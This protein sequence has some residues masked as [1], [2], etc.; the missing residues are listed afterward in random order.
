MKNM[1]MFTSNEVNFLTKGAKQRST[2]VPTKGEGTHEDDE[3]KPVEVTEIVGSFNT[4]ALNLAVEKDSYDES[5]S[6][7]DEES[8]N[9]PRSPKD[10]ATKGNNLTHKELALK[11]GV[12][13]SQGW[14]KEDYNKK[15]NQD[16]DSDSSKGDLDDDA[17]VTDW[18]DNWCINSCTGKLKIR[19]YKEEHEIMTHQSDWKLKLM[20]NINCL[21]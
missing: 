7:E 18:T 1:K 6:S 15:K 21:D 2:K 20:F 13:N 16:I 17:S 10:F 11:N 14:V 3:N 5:D 8:S 4:K 12:D 9:S 19:I